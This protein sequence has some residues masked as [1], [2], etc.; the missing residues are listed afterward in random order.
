MKKKVLTH[1]F[2]KIFPP[3]YSLE[4]SRGPREQPLA[5]PPT[6]NQEPLNEIRLASLSTLLSTL[7]PKWAVTRLNLG[8]DIG[9]E[10]TSDNDCTRAELNFLLWHVKAS[11]VSFWLSSSA[12]HWK[13]LIHNR[14]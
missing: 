4:G 14:P 5:P 12:V 11:D 13:G 9:A 7:R 8:Q 10:I 3:I 1:D 6:H 2:R